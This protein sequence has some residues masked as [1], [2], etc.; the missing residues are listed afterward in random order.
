MFVVGNGNGLLASTATHRGPQTTRPFYLTD[1]LQNGDVE[2]DGTLF[3]E[4]IQP[5]AV[6][7]PGG[8]PV[9][10]KN[11]NK[12]GGTTILANSALIVEGGANRSDL[13]GDQVSIATYKPLTRGTVD[14][15]Q[16]EQVGAI[17]FWGKDTSGND[18]KYGNV[19]A[20]ATNPI[21]G[22]EES[23]INISLSKNGTQTAYLQIDSSENIVKTL[24][25]AQLQSAGKMIALTD[26]SCNGNGAFN[27]ATAVQSIQANRMFLNG[28]TVPSALQGTVY[29]V[30]TV[31]GGRVNHDATNMNITG[32]TGTACA[33][34]QICGTKVASRATKNASNNITMAFGNSDAPRTIL[35]VQDTGDTYY[36]PCSYSIEVA[37]GGGVSFPASGP[38]ASFIPKYTGTYTFEMSYLFDTGA[39]GGVINNDNILGFNVSG[40]GN[41]YG[42]CIA[43]KA[44]TLPPS[45]SPI[46]YTISSMHQLTA[47]TVYTINFIYHGTAGAKGGNG[48]GYVLEANF[49]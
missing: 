6:P 46:A 15:V 43:G 35:S 47:E 11:P 7:A 22:Q 13:S 17:A 48:G 45:G 29:R 38:G 44:I 25:T 39:N 49:V 9:Y 36:V 20:V 33:V 40:V 2:I 14:Y 32:L 41:D 5:I 4:Q 26:I 12:L 21:N 31:E 30:D 42:A 27:T 19:Q 8:Q 1:T 34:Q 3:V 28:T 24:G 16:G 10:I 23:R 37:T 18:T